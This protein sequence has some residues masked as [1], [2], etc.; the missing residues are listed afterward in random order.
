MT[1]KNLALAAAIAMLVAISGLA[2]AR[3]A[4]SYARDWPAATRLQC[5]VSGD[6]DGRDQCAPLSRRTEIERLT[7]WTLPA[8]PQ[9]HRRANHRPVF[10]SWTSIREYGGLWNQAIENI[11]AP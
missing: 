9:G 8:F 6:A 5:F 2:S 1:T 3:A 11:G 4:G 7:W 10:V